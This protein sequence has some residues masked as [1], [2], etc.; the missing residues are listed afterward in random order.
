MLPAGVGTDVPAVIS[1]YEA[2]DFAPF[3]ALEMLWSE[4]FEMKWFPIVDASEGVRFVAEA[5]KEL[6]TLIS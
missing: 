2:E 5:M 1:I 4:Y 3:L 6:E